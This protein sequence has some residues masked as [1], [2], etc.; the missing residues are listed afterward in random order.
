[1]RQLESLSERADRRE[2]DRFNSIR[3]AAKGLEKGL[4]DA[5]YSY[6]R[7]VS[8]K[9]R[10]LSVKFAHQEYGMPEGGVPCCLVV[11]NVLP[12]QATNML[13]AYLSIDRSGKV[14]DYL[15]VI[16]LFAKSHRI[17]DPAGGF[18]ST[19]AW[20][21]MAIHVLLRF[22]FLPNIH[23]DVIYRFDSDPTLLVLG[24][25]ENG[26]MNGDY[27]GPQQQQQDVTFTTPRLMYLPARYVAKLEE[28]SVLEL[29]D[30]FF[31]YY[32]QSFDVFSSVVSLKGGGELLR[33][34]DWPKSSAVLW[35]LSIE[36]SAPPLL[37]DV[38]LL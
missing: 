26:T 32:V 20:H 36:V 30:T 17:A 19:F 1:M 6:V 31:R 18:L 5:G 29:L 34:T 27:T 13:S 10:F 28:T 8:H 7:T 9:T 23:D 12:V 14:R 25:A 37:V 22:G 33:K 15:H 21:T 4:K 38:A 3:K 24:A 16:K 2:A 11:H 35:R